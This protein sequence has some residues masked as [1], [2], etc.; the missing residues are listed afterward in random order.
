MTSNPSKDGRKAKRSIYIL[1]HGPQTFCQMESVSIF[2]EE[3]HQLSLVVIFSYI[4]HGCPIQSENRVQ[5]KNQTRVLSSAKIAPYLISFDHLTLIQCKIDNNPWS[6]CHKYVMDIK[7]HIFPDLLS[8]KITS[9]LPAVSLHLSWC[10]QITF[11]SNQRSTCQQQKRGKAL[12]FFKVQVGQKLHL[13]AQVH[14]VIN[15]NPFP[16]RAQNGL[17]FL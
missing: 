12:F 13:V 2:Q 3:T 4:S 11:D 9:S 15:P 16:K 7:N 1:L 5:T 10:I 8:P 14:R 6:D 17:K